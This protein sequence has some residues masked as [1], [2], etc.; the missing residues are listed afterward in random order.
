MKSKYDVA[1]LGWWYG[2]NYGSILTYFGLNRA[3]TK[4]D[5]KVLM[6]NEPLGYNNWR[7]KWPKDI[8]SIRFAK[9]QGY[10]FTQQ[11][12][13]SKL[14][15]LNKKAKAFMVGS[16]QLWNPRIGRVN[17]DLFLDFVSPENKRFSYGTSFGNRDVKKFQAPFIAKH[18]LNLGKFDA[19]SVREEYALDIAKKVFDADATLVVDPVFLLER[20]EYEALAKKAS[21]QQSGTYMS[22]FFL[23]PT[24]EKYSTALGIADKLGIDKLVVIPNPDGGYER[25]KELATSDRISVIKEDS[26]EN[27]LNAYMNAS[28]SITDSFHGTAFA[29]IFNNPFSSIYNTK[30]GADRFINLLKSLGF[31][32][33]R[34]VYEEDTAETISKNPNVTFDINFDAARRYMDEGR[35]QS[36]NW[37][38]TVLSDPS[39]PKA[40]QAQGPE[41]IVVNRPDF[42]TNSKSWKVVKTPG[43]THLMKAYP[44]LKIGYHA[45]CPLPEKPV[46]GKCYQIQM[47]WKPRST[48][49]VINVHLRNPK[50]GKF[51]V[52][53]YLDN[54][55]QKKTRTDTFEF[56]CTDPDATELMFGAVHFDGPLKGLFTGAT[57]HSI[58]SL[59]IPQVTLSAADMRKTASAAAKT[60]EMLAMRDL[61]RY[62]GTYAQ[63]MHSKNAGNARAIMMFHAHAI[64]KGLSRSNLR[65]GFGR[66]AVPSLAKEM[67]KWLAGKGDPKDV[68]FEIGAS[69]MHAYFEKHKELGKDVSHFFA[70]FDEGVRAHFATAK[71][72]MGGVIQAQAERELFDK[73][74]HDRDFSDVV[75][76]RRSV[77]E[78]T[79]AK[80]SK[81]RIERAIHSAGQSPSVCNR[82]PARLHLFTDQSVIKKA[83]DIQGGL[84][85]Y[86]TPPN[87]FLI[88]SDL[89]AYLFAPERNQA[90]VDGGL[91]MM[92]LLLGLENEGLG[93]CCLNT[94]MGVE[95]ET[96]LRKL[97]KI[98]ESEVFICFVAFGEYDPR[99]L[100]PISKRVDLDE[101][102]V[103]H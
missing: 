45:Y 57:V 39:K 18:K 55:G 63:N 35:K 99:V 47:R 60:T 22:V 75:F 92:S 83:V 80:V 48:V 19:I 71:P 66:V 6:V 72:H 33:T 56:K 28:Y 30:R 97:L 100:T 86:P 4:L 11:E 95:K 41:K 87:L 94:A 78:F 58:S 32:D 16:D 46:L 23:D 65:P 37:L 1:I 29:A 52:I 61:Q 88:T 81:D 102:L 59:E 64:E 27:F 53:G 70:L 93:A 10:N 85:G 9:Q 74:N 43:A 62:V 34:R 26:P 38:K 68:Y 40:K 31:A 103:A 90:Y 101:V 13:F 50:T 44:G 98:P 67:N 42:T 54:T 15:A 73:P 77:R 82:Q 79:S 51:R 21:I 7:V 89:N 3:L 91:F 24:P 20:A 2:K 96:K 49:P 14:P 76:G 25:A 17:D 69:V 84:G 5:Y 12:H 36:L 8:L